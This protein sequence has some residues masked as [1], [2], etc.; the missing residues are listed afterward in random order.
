MHEYYQYDAQ[1]LMAAPKI[2]LQCMADNETVFFVD[3]NA[4]MADEEGYLPDD[5]SKDGC[6]LYGKYYEMWA[7]FLCD[8][9]I[10]PD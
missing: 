10:L 9:A 2:P 5:Y 8:S 3:V 6:H 4:V 7:K 1:Q